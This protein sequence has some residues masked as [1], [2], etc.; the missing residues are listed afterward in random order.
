MGLPEEVVEVLNLT[1]T[2]IF[3]V[4]VFLIVVVTLCSL[5]GKAAISDTVLFKSMV[6]A[7]P[8]V[9]GILNVP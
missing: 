7:V 9:F 3:S 1:N 2:Y 6:K 8:L 4:P 5:P